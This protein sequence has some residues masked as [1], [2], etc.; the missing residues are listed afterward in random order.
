MRELLSGK[1]NLILDEEDNLITM[2]WLGESRDMNPSAI[3]D[4]Y[5]EEFVKEMKTKTSKPLL[6]DFSKLHIMNS[7]TVKPI[8]LFIRLLEE[9]SIKAD[10]VYNEEITWQKASFISLGIITKSYKYVSVKPK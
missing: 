9:N 4:P 2:T 8:L 5:I 6:V 1:L 10:I 3:L 7:S